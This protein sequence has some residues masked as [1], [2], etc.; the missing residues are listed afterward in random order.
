MKQSTPSF[1]FLT[2]ILVFSLIIYSGC[3]KNPC[4]ASDCA[5]G[6]EICEMCEEQIASVDGAFCGDYLSE[7][8]G[9]HKLI[10]GFHQISQQNGSAKEVL[11]RVDVYFDM[12]DGMNYKVAKA[13]DDAGLLTDLVNLIS[14]EKAEYFRLSSASGNEI[15]KLPKSTGGR[16]QTYVRNPQNYNSANNYA[17]LDVAADSI[18]R[19]HDRQS[20]LITD[21]ELANKNV[22]GVVDPKFPWGQIP[23]KKW[24]G[25]GNRLDF[26]VKTVNE[27]RLFF[28]F[29]TPRLTAEKGNS[30]IE[31]YLEST[32]DVKKA[33][34]Y[35]HLKFTL[36]DYALEEVDRGRPAKEAGLSTTFP[37]WVVDYSIRRNL[38][39]GYEHLHIEDEKNFKDFLSGFEQG[40]YNED[41][42]SE[43]EERNKLFYDLLF[44]N[45]FVNYQIADLEIK[46]RDFSGPLADYMNYLKCEQAQSV[47]FED[48]EGQKKTYWCNPWAN[49]QDTEGCVF[50]TDE[51]GG[52]E[53][54]EVFGLHEESKISVDDKQFST[55]KIAIKPSENF[56]VDEMYEMASCRIDLYIKNVEYSEGRQNF[57]VLTWK[58][59]NVDYTG[60]SESIRLAM[61]E[62]K[63]Q[64][65]R[66]YTYYITF[67]LPY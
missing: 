22:S 54:K 63:P 28:I 10:D 2:R 49:C 61:R 23:F 14:G 47:T 40:E 11:D 41:L 32:A 50:R 24:L 43:Y 67:G 36:S 56:N 37:D 29:F 53:I 42:K 27:E 64:N 57:D 62:L 5:C 55:A 12:S 66:I 39:Q 51:T 35:H 16:I 65:K 34:A 30:L 38:D 15:E 48:E 19:N 33:D 17:P 52:R 26:V 20:V 60:L 44:T 31:A 21:G 58:Y 6:E 45:E 3:S 7:A 59:K 18:V 25:E 4:P 46:V 9:F 8:N 13:E 1:F